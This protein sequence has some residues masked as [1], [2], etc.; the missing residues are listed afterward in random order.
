MFKG[1]KSN[2]KFIFVVCGG[3]EHI[4]TLHFSLRALQKFSQNEIIVL[5]DSARNE[6][7][8]MFYNV[9]EIET[10]HEFNNHQASIFLKTG[11]C[12]FLPRGPLYCYLDT[13]VVALDSNV[14]MVFSYFKSPVT[15]A[16]DHCRIN[17]FSPSA[18][19]CGCLEQF[20]MDTAV[21]KKHYQQFSTFSFKEQNHIKKCMAEINLL[22]EKSKRNRFIYFLHQ[23]QYALPLKYYYLNTKYNLNRNNWLYI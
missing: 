2:K 15:F 4:D 12:K 5:T 22:V 21:I 20:D 14:D 17:A 18:I 16:S 11:A 6:I 10:P 7:P 19:N 9:I 3:K 1:L 23:L 8:I 13:D